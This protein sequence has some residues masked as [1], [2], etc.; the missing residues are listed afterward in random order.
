MTLSISFEKAQISAFLSIAEL[1][2][3]AWQQNRNSEFIPDGEHVWRLWV[4]H[5]LVFAAKSADKIIGAILAFPCMSGVYCVH[6]VFVDQSQRG[7][8]IG[9]SL[10]EILL[11][12]IDTL[13]V[14]CFLTVDP[15]NEAAIRLYAK[16]GFTEKVF[17]KGYYRANED[18]YVLTRHCKA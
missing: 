17:V 3:I 18:R 4:E 15:L 8:G 14:D 2:R 10:F 13:K 12:E 9:S 5:A 6:K 1:D 11:K 16:W 7:K